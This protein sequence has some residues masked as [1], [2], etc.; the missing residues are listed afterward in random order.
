[1]G[2][3]AKKVEVSPELRAWVEKAREWRTTLD[4]TENAAMEYLLHGEESGVWRGIYES[5]AECLRVNNLFDV[6]RYEKWKAARATLGD[7]VV[8]RIGVHGAITATRVADPSLRAKVVSRMVESAETNGVP[9]SAQSAAQIATQEGALP[10]A[11][12]LQTA[13]QQSLADMK[14]E[15]DRLRKENADLRRKLKDAES[16]LNKLRAAM[17]VKKG[18]KR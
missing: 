11:P 12:R 2:A 4:A 15:C 3:A 10:R 6:A 5:F 13:G 7:K 18:S 16:E 1:M 8:A 9:L 17:P 14:A